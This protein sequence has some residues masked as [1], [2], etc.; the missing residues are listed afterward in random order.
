MG[1]N[2]SEAETGI[3]KEKLSNK[4]EIGDEMSVELREAV[5]GS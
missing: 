5:M 1:S 2:Q 3:G 4:L